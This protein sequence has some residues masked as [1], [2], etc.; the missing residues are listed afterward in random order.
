MT[1][2]N[3]SISLFAPLM[4]SVAGT[5]VIIQISEAAALSLYL[6]RAS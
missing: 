4:L 3:P 1:P 6:K 2:S 5:Y